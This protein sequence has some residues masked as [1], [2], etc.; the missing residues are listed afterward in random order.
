MMDAR[1]M[2]LEQIRMAGL[3]ALRRSLGVV[4]M[5]RFLQQSET[6]WGDYTKDRNQ[7]L[8]DPDLTELAKKI[9][10][11]HRNRKKRV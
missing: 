4:G 7:W 5:V 1:T 10:T 3:A 8:G 2:T 6:G 11:R 9:Q